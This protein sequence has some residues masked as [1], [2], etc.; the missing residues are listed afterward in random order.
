MKDS[1]EQ[2]KKKLLENADLM[3]ANGLFKKLKVNLD[4]IKVMII[5]LTDM[6]NTKGEFF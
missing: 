1:L 3:A 4:E 2:N 5:E 6:Q